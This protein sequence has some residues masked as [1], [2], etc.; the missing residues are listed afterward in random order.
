LPQ[1]LTNGPPTFQRIVNQILGPNRWKHVLAYIDDII[2]YSKHFSE[3]IRHIEEV[4]ALLHE[5]NFKLNVDKCEIA[6]TEIL[7]LGHV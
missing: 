7:F 4:C 1:G 5:A 6:R 3:H 2:I